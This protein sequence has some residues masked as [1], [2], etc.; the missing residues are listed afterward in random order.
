MRENL[1]YV[2]GSSPEGEAKVPEVSLDKVVNLSAKETNAA[3]E[4]HFENK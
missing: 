1:G 2:H 3:W 4:K